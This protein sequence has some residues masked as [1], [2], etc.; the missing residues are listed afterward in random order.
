[1]EDKNMKNSLRLIVAMVFAVMIGFGFNTARAQVQWTDAQKEVLKNVN[2]YWSMLA[3]GDVKGFLDYVHKDYIGWDDNEPLPTTKEESQKWLEYA[4]TGAKVPV[5]SIQPLAIKIYGDVA[6][7]HYYYSMVVIG[8]DGK[9][10]NEHGRWT[11]ILL[12]QGTKW[13]LIGDNGG[14][15]KAKE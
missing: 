11:D 14:A 12:K 10:V 13:V 1:M 5:Y 3:K 6:F 9:K 4:F 15:E 7:V 2:D 8:A